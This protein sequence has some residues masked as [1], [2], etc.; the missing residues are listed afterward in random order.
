MSNV[1]DQI[2]ATKKEEVR[3]GQAIHQLNDLLELMAA[4]SAPRG[5]HQAI[6]QRLH[7][8]Q[9]AVIAEVKKASPSKG[10]I[11]ADFDPVQIA[12]S[13]QQGDATCLS[14][15][16]DAQ[17]FKGHN[18]YLQQV[19]EAVSLPLLRKDFMIDPWQIHESR[20]L[21]AD[22]VLLIVACLSDGQL[23]ELFAAATELQMDV[24]MEVHD[25]EEMQRALNTPATLIGINNRNLK[26]FDTSL[27]TSEQLCTMVPE[28]CTLVSESGIHVSAD[29][30]YLQG[31]GINTYLIGESFMRHSDPGQQLHKLMSGQV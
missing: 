20:A 14:V 3:K 8:G 27:Q 30:N 6:R 2:V 11:R 21:G 9:S 7:A 23:A 25:A 10:I 1:L 4:Q 19:R 22:C 15:L 5:F 16:T 13:Y 26:T 12:R 18:S 28:D 29:I 24:L 17:Y 31:I